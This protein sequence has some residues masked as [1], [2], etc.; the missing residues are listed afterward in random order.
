ME[1]R[2]LQASDIFTMVKILNGI[3]LTKIKS[4]IDFEKIKELRKNMTDK[5]ADDIASQVG[6]DVILSVVSVMFENLPAIESD[7]Y[8]FVGSLAGIKPTEVAKLDLNVF[9][10]LIFDIFKKE[11]FVDFFKRASKLIKSE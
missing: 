6:T 3:G 8:K 4:A 9:I 2:N 1:L 7:L 11:E 5:N 10:D